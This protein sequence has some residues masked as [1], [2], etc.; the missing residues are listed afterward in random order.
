MNINE[1]K[2]IL[3]IYRPGTRDAD[4]PEI[5]AALQLVDTDPEL[6]HWFE[7]HCA[8]QNALRQKFQQIS[9]PAGLKEQIISEQAAAAKAASLREKIVGAVAVAAIVI[10]IAVLAI[11]YMPRSEKPL[12]AVTNNLS[13][14]LSQMAADA[15][16]SYYMNVESNAGKIQSY[17]AQNQAPSDYVLPAGLQAVA[18]SGCAVEGWQNSKVSMICF[19]T[20]KPLPSGQQSDLWLFVIDSS[21]VP[22]TS[23]I[24]SPR[25]QVAEGLTTAIW[26]QGG[27]LY[28]LGMKGDVQTLQKF[29]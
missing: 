10:S 26:T 18:L 24:T 1:A 17:F 9:I 2:Q 14:Y 11:V 4:D 12:P 20:G 6:S 28:V 13:T 7:E 3:L 19:R 8:R 15:S 23:S 16:T 29:L 27:K 5:A 21:A 22:G 25:F